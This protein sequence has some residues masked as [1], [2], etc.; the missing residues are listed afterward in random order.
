MIKYKQYKSFNE[1][2]CV[3]RFPDNASIP[4]DPANTDYQQFKI[5]VANGVPLEDQDGNVMTQDAV[6]EFLATLP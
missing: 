6:T 2:V 1:I 5:D 4:L 3:I